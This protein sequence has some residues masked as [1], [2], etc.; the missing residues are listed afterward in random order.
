MIFDAN[1]NAVHSYLLISSIEY[2]EL[3]QELTHATT[4]QSLSEEVNHLIS[5]D[6]RTKNP[7]AQKQTCQ[8]QKI[9]PVERPPNPIDYR[10]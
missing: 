9:L 4:P 3:N 10:R 5:H 7:N 8:S 6:L 1:S 2:Q